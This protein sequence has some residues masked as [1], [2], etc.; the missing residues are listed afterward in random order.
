MDPTDTD[1]RLPGAEVSGSSGGLDVQSRIPLKLIFKQVSKDRSVSQTAKT[2]NG[3]PAGEEEFEDNEERQFDC[4]RGE[5]LR[6]KKK[7]PECL[8]ENFKIKI[9][10]EKDDSPV[11]FCDKCDLPVKIYG[12]M[13]LSKHA[14]CYE[15][16]NLY[17][18]RKTEITCIQAVVLLRCRLR[19]AREVLSSRVALS[20][21]A[22]EHICLKETYML[23]STTIIRAEKLVTRVP[24]VLYQQL[25]SLKCC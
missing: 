25:K 5:L 9:I 15:G 21:E 6:K 11:N 10:G 1:N 8:W 4:K 13:S 24:Q 23:I 19:S 7:I 16:A 17:E 12:R 14:F 3:M 18:K 22:R 2:M 20:R